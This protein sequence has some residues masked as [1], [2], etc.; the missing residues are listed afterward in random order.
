MT[1]PAVSRAQSAVS[2]FQNA[3]FLV[4]DAV[5]RILD[6]VFLNHDASGPAVALRSPLSAHGD[7]TP[8]SYIMLSNVC[9]QRWWPSSLAPLLKSRGPGSDG[10]RCARAIRASVP[11]VLMFALGAGN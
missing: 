3:V 8:I 2:R 1:R 6:V 4:R 7:I 9:A 5:S 10:M 11:R